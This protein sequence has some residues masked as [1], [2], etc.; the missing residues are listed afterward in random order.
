MGVGSGDFV[1][2]V[3]SILKFCTGHWSSLVSIV[4]CFSNLVLDLLDCL[5]P[6]GL[7]LPELMKLLDPLYIC[8]S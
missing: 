6:F 8:R 7:I 1:K 3:E 4:G 2:V 5:D